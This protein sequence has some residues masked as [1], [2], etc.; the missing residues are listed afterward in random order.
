M[1]R[2][3]ETE[4]RAAYRRPLDEA[5]LSR[6]IQHIEQLA[7]PPAR[8]HRRWPVPLAAAAAVAALM[9]GTITVIAH[10]NETPT[11]AVAV[12][13]DQKPQPSKLTP[14][15]TGKSRA[16]A[17]PSPPSVAPIRTSQGGPT[18]SSVTPGQELRIV[19]GVVWDP[20]GDGHPDHAAQVSSA[21]DGQ[22]STSW[23]TLLYA[24][25]FPSVTKPG[26]GIALQLAAPASPT[27][28]T[29]RS[30]T[31]GTTIQVRSA[32]GFDPVYDQT[33]A[34]GQGL[35]GSTG[36]LSIKL[37]HAPSSRYLIVFVT[38]MSKS[39][40]NFASTIN[41]IDVLG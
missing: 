20:I 30:T 3:D 23:S 41:E 31:P 13:H 8:A 14:T 9:A 33:T 18:S 21:Y 2:R 7:S 10:H 6:L 5:S 26:V 15:A 38:G 1:L 17:Q 25:N 11:A 40:V 22:P 37:R 34:L 28:V 35:I 12:H 24:Q 16:A 36:T 39:G 29:V 27:A 32:S 19:R 4:L